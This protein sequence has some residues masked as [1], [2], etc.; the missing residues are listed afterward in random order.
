MLKERYPLPQWVV[1]H[2]RIKQKSCNMLRT[3]QVTKFGS[4]WTIGL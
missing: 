3:T 4:N 2:F 1:L